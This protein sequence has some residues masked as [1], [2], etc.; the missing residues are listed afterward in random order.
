MPVVYNIGEKR[1]FYVGNGKYKH[2]KDYRS[3]SYAVRDSEAPHEIV[4]KTGDF[5]CGSNGKL[6]STIWGGVN[7]DRTKKAI[8]FPAAK[9]MVRKQLRRKKT[10]ESATTNRRYRRGRH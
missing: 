4:S 1:T 10:T 9:E 5:P 7:A 2:A 3:V 8:D 6:R